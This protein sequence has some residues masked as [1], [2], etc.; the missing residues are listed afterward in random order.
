V[1]VDGCVRRSGF[2]GP[3]VTDSAYGS[4]TKG[5]VFKVIWYLLFRHESDSV[6]VPILRYQEE[7]F[8]P[9]IWRKARRVQSLPVKTFLFFFRHQQARVNLSTKSPSPLHI[10]V[11]NNQ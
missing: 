6:V 3:G 11:I 5:D 10:F 9:K 1:V 4:Q 2:L 7:H 8:P